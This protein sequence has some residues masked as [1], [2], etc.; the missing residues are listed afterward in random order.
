MLYRK[1]FKPHASIELLNP[2][3]CDGPWAVFMFNFFQQFRHDYRM[4]G[5]RVALHNAKV[6]LGK[7]FTV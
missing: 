6:F 7:D 2:D 1:L 3:D 5:F 4:Y